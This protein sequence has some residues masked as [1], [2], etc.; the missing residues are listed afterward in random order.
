MMYFIHIISSANSNHFNM[1]AFV[2][3]ILVNSWHFGC[4]LTVCLKLGLEH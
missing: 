4:V 2:P 3:E 1:K